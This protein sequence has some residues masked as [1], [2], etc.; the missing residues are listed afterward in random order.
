MSQQ[1]ST[2]TDH[3]IPLTDGRRLGYSEYGTTHGT[4]VLFFHGAPGSSYIHQD[5]ALI[6]AQND[7]CLIAVDRPGYGLSDP[8]PNRTFLSFADDIN[9]FTNT[10][11]IKKF[12]IIGFSA[13]SPYPLACAYK[14]PERINK[15]ALVGSLAPVDVPG[16]ME[17]MSPMAAGLFAL[18]QSNPEELRKTFTAIAPSASALI[19][20]ASASVGDWD[21][22]VFQARAA[23]FEKEY[24]HT[25]RNGIEGIAS[26]YDLFTGVWGFP[27]N[28]CK[29]EVNLYSGSV[30]A[31]TP[32]AMTHYL[33]TQLPNSH[34]HLFQDE[35]HFIL[36]PHWEEI[37]K[38]VI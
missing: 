27:I 3:F 32:P 23:E 6:A 12:S 26:D 33:S 16:V 25:L 37:L 36:Y 2:F 17:G 35:G 10:L 5:L 11:G 18:A 14:F 8:Q 19:G 22:K 28:E 31:N 9:A 38:A 34:V 21:K 30:D 7:V 20:A 15:I 4:P 29:T 24:E 13:G 1:K